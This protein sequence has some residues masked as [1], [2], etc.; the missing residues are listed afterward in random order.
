MMGI[1]NSK[2]KFSVFIKFWNGMKVNM[3]KYIVIC[4]LNCGGKYLCL[5][6]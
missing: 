6:W 4:G 5:G 1:L 2:I 3:W